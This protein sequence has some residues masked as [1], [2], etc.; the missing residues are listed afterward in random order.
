MSMRRDEKIKLLANAL[1]TAAGSCFTVGV[2]APTVAVLIN[3]GD[4]R[5]KVTTGV[6]AL[7]AIGWLFTAI[8]LHI[9]AR[10]QLDKLDE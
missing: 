3:L 7:N 4:A 1:N 2:V 9:L 8:V 10:R 5:S 6:L